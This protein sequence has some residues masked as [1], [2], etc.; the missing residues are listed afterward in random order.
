MNIQ[1]LM[2]TYNGAPYLETQ[3]NSILA[4]EIPAMYLLIRDDGSTDNTTEILETYHQKYP[5]IS[6]YKGNNIGVQKSFFDLISHSDAKADFIAFAD[7]DDEWMPEKLSRAIHCL[8][9]MEKESGKQT[10]LLYCG[11]QQLVDSNL[12]PIPNNVSRIVR[13]PSFG[14]ALVQNICTGCTTVG[15]Q[16]LLTLIRNYSPSNIDDIIMHDWW[17]YLTA[18]CFGKVYY[19]SNAYIRYRQHG[20][21]TFGAQTSQWG[22]LQYRLKELLK[23]R[24]EIYR[25]GKMFLETF[26]KDLLNKSHKQS[27]EML[28]KLLLSEKGFKNRISVIVDTRFFRQKKQDD[29]IFR[30]IVLIGKL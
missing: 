23:P 12:K 18:S 21:N 30:G 25:Q 11:A 24:G 28:E 5:W 13:K 14:N 1:I 17:L 6:Y 2:S 22:L 19:D 27:F 29:I 7:Q 15:N 4:Q 10:P 16:S 9:Q 26:H 8:S 3:L 20:K